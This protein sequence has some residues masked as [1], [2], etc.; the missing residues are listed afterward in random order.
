[1]NQI[2]MPILHAAPLTLDQVAVQHL[3]LELGQ[4]FRVEVVGDAELVVVG[5]AQLCD[6]A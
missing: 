4:V 1:M 6:S 5:A 2:T 3:A